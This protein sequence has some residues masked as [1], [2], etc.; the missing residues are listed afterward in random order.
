ML[1]VPGPLFE[2]AAYSFAVVDVDPNHASL[3]AVGELD[4]AAIE[5]LV[6]ILAAQETAGRTSIRLDLSA[7]TFMDCACLGGLVDARRR[8]MALH[9]DL[10]LTNV[11]PWVL[12]LLTLTGLTALTGLTDNVPTSSE[13][14]SHVGGEGHRPGRS[15]GLSPREAEIIALVTQG[16][17]NRDI[18]DRVSLSISTIKTYIRTAYRKMHVTTRA[19]AVLW[20]SDNGFRP[21]S[22]RTTD[23]AVLVQPAATAPAPP[24]CP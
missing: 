15:D 16:L 2:A 21:D 3:M 7:V 19:Q 1:A 13:P 14:E 10:L 11:S 12:R 17:S 9:G 8:L 20:G 5:D 24:S 22:L 4:L 18:A 6:A 23:P